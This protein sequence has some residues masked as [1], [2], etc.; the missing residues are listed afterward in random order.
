MTVTACEGHRAG[1]VIVAHW[2]IPP[3]NRP[4]RGN[5]E[6][7]ARIMDSVP[8]LIWS[9]TPHGLLEYGN[10]A[11][12]VAVTADCGVPVENAL[13]PRLHCADQE[14][15]RRQWLAA[16]RNGQAY[17]CEYRLESGAHDSRRWLLERGT[18][19]RDATTGALQRWIMT[20]TPIDRYKRTEE[21]LRLQLVQRDDFL[22]T[23]L[24]ELRNP[25][26]PIAGALERLRRSP[27]DALSVGVARGIIQRQLRQLS[28][29][30]DDLLDVSRISHGGIRLQ[31]RVVA[32]QDI[33]AAAVETAGPLLD[34][35]QQELTVGQ[36]ERAVH[37]FA[38]PVRLT[39]VITNLLMN[40]AKFT[41]RGGHVSIIS[42]EKEGVV[43]IRVRDNGAGIPADKLPHIFDL[44]VQADPGSTAGA[45][46]LGVGLAVAR[47]MVELHGGTLS[48]R[49]EGPGRGSEFTVLLPGAH[50]PIGSLA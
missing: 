28:S 32:L 13:L 16:L 47:Q 44:Y 45:R 2:E 1:N 26:T 17:E 18:P 29:L 35:R 33:V 43:S 49:S 8:H 3:G 50:R 4:A 11:W 34:V 40:A 5:T 36:G 27:N 21:A 9:T 46:G 25:L 10:S 42:G 23:V 30:V 24:H 12:K 19:V 14:A 7:V 22:A 15:W 41:D 31:R 6:I 48:A 37:L 20:G 39:Q 38:D